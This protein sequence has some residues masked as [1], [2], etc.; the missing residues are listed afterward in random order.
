MTGCNEILFLEYFSLLYN[1]QTLLT[2]FV[3]S[4]SCTVVY[5]VKNEAFLKYTKCNGVLEFVESDLGTFTK[6][7][8]F[9][10]LTLSYFVSK[11]DAF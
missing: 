2:V 6:N 1:I 3:F 11:V 4:W 5:N 10:S 8:Y 9:T 7:K